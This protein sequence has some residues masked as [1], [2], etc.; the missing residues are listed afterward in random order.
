LKIDDGVFLFFEN[1]GHPNASFDNFF[2]A[3]VSG[4]HCVCEGATARRKQEAVAAVAA[5][6]AAARRARRPRPSVSWLNYNITKLVF[7][8]FE[9]CN[10]A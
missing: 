6:A 4:E 3:C 7:G 10:G 2:T 8:R 1:H 5:A 9:G